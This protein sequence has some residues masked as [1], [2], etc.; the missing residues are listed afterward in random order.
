[1]EP[2]RTPAKKL[3]SKYLGLYNNWAKSWASVSVKATAV[4]SCTKL[5]DNGEVTYYELD[6]IIDEALKSFKLRKGAPIEPR[7]LW[8]KVG[9][10]INAFC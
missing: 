7:E 6:K 3:V 1:M 4:R 9:K 5:L 2:I 8:Q 10:A